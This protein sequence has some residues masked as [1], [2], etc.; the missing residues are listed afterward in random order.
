MTVGVSQ[1]GHFSP[2][3]KRRSYFH[4]AFLE[5]LI[6]QSIRSSSEP[7]VFEIGN[8]PKNVGGSPVAEGAKFL[9]SS[10]VHD[11]VVGVAESAMADYYLCRGKIAY[12]RNQRGAT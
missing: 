9:V 6:S 5:S 4:P 8:L 1:V 12:R 7:S 3:L 10:R 2:S 11:G